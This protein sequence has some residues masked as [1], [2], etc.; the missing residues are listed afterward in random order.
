MGRLEK[1]CGTVAL[2]VT[3]GLL[4]STPSPS[5]LLGVINNPSLDA[6]SIFASIGNI[7]RC[8]A[9]QIEEG[10][11]GGAE[12]DGICI[13]HCELRKCENL[14]FFPDKRVVKVQKEMAT[15]AM[16][17]ERKARR[18]RKGRA[19]RQSRKERRIS[20][21]RNKKNRC[22]EQQQKGEGG[23]GWKWSLL[24]DEC[25]HCSERHLPEGANTFYCDIP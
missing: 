5:P 23:G 13:R 15:F 19:G 11:G 4:P 24:R 2:V 6:F 10:V 20:R 3:R 1:V 9:A 22:G 21:R 18:T 8:D 12:L 16:A 17:R 7:W 14:K 25:S